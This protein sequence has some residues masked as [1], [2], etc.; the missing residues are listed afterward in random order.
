M[1]KSKDKEIINRLFNVVAKQQQIITKLAQVNPMPPPNSLEPQN[2]TKQEARAILNALPKQVR[3]VV[4]DIQVVPGRDS[5]VVKIK[6]VPG[7]G[8]AQVFQAI[9][10]TVNKLQQQNVLPGASYTL[11]EVA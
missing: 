7:K 4:A 5:N 8:S 11:T 3:A 1:S 6:Y 2:F 9:Q 10:Q